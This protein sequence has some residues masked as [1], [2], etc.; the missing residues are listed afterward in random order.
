MIHPYAVTLYS[1][2][3]KG[4][5]ILSWPPLVMSHTTSP[6]AARLIDV[7]GG[8]ACR[9][10]T[11]SASMKAVLY[12]DGHYPQGT[13]YALNQLYRSCV[14]GDGMYRLGT[15]EQKW[16]RFADSG[17]CI[18]PSRKPRCCRFTGLIPKADKSFRKHINSPFEIE[19]RAAAKGPASSKRYL[20]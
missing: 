5:C 7:G 4:A 20:Y 9:R 15:K 16:E 3:G 1:R 17:I 18:S 10:H 12:K 11:L 13:A 19:T 8:T 6:E 2:G 14:P